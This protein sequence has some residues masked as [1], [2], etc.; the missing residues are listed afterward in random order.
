MGEVVVHP[1]AGAIQDLDALVQMV[2]QAVTCDLLGKFTNSH[3]LPYI[4]ELAESVGA[5]QYFRLV[6]FPS[7]VWLPD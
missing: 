7:N 4:A 2:K 5:A 1:R 6:T 3:S